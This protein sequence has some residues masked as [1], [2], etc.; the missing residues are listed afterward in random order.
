MQ[1][2]AGVKSIKSQGRVT[3]VLR[4]TDAMKDEKWNLELV[5]S[6]GKEGPALGYSSVE[7]L[8]PRFRHRLI[9]FP[10]IS[11]GERASCCIRQTSHIHIVTSPAPA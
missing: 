4:L 2:L 6:V 7:Y 8:L 10:K 9:S 1:N 5:A 11:E 3:S